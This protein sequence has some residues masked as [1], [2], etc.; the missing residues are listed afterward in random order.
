MLEVT[1]RTNV[2]LGR[3]GAVK[4]SDSNRDTMIPHQILGLM[5]NDAYYIG[6]TCPGPRDIWTWLSEAAAINYSSIHFPSIAV[7]I[8]YLQ[9]FARALYL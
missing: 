2:E 3:R 9:G 1:K 8:F 5:E 4:A 7:S 6:S